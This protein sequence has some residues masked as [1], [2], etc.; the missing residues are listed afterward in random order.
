MY[1]TVLIPST[2]RM[3]CSCGVQRE[4]PHHRVALG[5][6]QLPMGGRAERRAPTVRSL[7]DTRCC[8]RPRS[9]TPLIRA[10]PWVANK[11]AQPAAIDLEPAVAP[12]GQLDKRAASAS[13]RRDG[14]QVLDRFRCTQ[15]LSMHHSPR[16]S[17][18]RAAMA[19]VAPP[20]TAIAGGRAG[21]RGIMC[22]THR[23]DAC[24]L[25]RACAWHHGSCPHTNLWFALTRYTHPPRGPSL[26]LPKRQPVASPCAARARGPSRGPQIP[27][28]C[29]RPIA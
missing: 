25:R 8:R 14:Q 10:L 17:G 7:R 11:L 9:A 13:W 21:G 16:H 19:A 4:H 15:V 3:S 23:R 24:R 28:Q 2:P 6:A 27:P 18:G 26:Q 29:L 5:W 12:R 20:G 1:N 22:C